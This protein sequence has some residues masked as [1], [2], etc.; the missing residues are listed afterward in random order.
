MALAGYDSYLI[1]ENVHLLRMIQQDCKIEMYVGGLVGCKGD[2]Y[3]RDDALSEKDAYDFHLWQAEQLHLA[4]V[5]FLYAGIIL[6]PRNSCPC[7]HGLF[8]PVY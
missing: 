8:E 2:A 6:V 5:D 3:S 7:S 4:G 1:A